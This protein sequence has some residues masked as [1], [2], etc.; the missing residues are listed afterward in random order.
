MQIVKL[1]LSTFLCA[2]MLFIPALDAQQQQQQDAS[3]SDGYTGPQVPTS[4]SLGV[5]QT[6]QSKMLVL[7]NKLQNGQQPTAS[8]D[9][10]ASTSMQAYFANSDETGWTANLQTWII[11]NAD[12]FTTLNL[13][14]AQLQAAYT[15]LQ[16]TGAIISYHQFVEGIMGDSLSDREAFL[17][18]V[19]TSGLQAFHSNMVRALTVLSTANATS[20]K[21]SYASLH[22][23]GLGKML[24]VGTWTFSWAAAGMY[25]AIVGL[26]VATGGAGAVALGIGIG[27]AGVGAAAVG[28]AGE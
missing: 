6:M 5:V 19:E 7:N 10:A 16:G 26:V 11:N 3:P 4:L 12:L 8:D 24:L 22:R 20:G 25:L 9:A 13:S 28:V 15:N 23:R 14:V 27:V 17:N 1:V 2:G 21:L 18:F